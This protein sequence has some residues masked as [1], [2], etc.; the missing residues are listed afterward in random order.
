MRRPTWKRTVA[1]RVA[2]A[3]ALVFVVV[4]ATFFLVNAL[5]GGPG[6]IADDPRVPP[7]HA[8]RLRARWGLDRPLAERYARF[9]VAAARGDWGPSLS[10]QRPVARVLADALP[11]SLALALA[12]LAIELGGGLALGVA[13]AS[14]PHGALDHALRAATLVLRA[15]PGFW[16]ALLLLGTFA[17][18]W[19][20]LPAGGVASSGLEP[21]SLLARAADLLRH[22][23][24]PALAVGLPAAAGA[25]RFVRAALLEI[26]GEPFLLAARARGLAARTVLARHAL[27][28]AAAPLAQLAGFGVGGLLS[29]AL[30]VEV[31]FAW[32]GLGRVTYEALLARDYPVLVAGAA[33]AAVAV[34]VGSALAELLHAAL[35]PRVRDA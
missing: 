29:G 21:A 14:R 31:V 18:R 25:A 19:P 20:V 8:E 35:D 32:P 4:S 6:R 12:A 17:V 33:L 28:A 16:L 22:L 5:P 23:V 7:A 34:V 11:W 3:A 9:L 24:L 10:Q 30:A 13:A 1:R 26:A 2:G 15:V 27:P